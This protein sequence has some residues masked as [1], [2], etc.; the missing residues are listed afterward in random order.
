M[1][2]NGSAYGTKLKLFRNET[3]PM[4]ERLKFFDGRYVE[5]S[6]Q[7]V[8]SEDHTLALVAPNGLSIVALATLLTFA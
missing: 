4:W 7:A 2:I 8:T 6:A 3:V 1:S 5:N